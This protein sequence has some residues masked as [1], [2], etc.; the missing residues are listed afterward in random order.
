[1]VYPGHTVTAMNI[2]TRKSGNSCTPSYRQNC[3]NMEQLIYADITV[4]GI[5][6]WIENYH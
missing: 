5:T 1:M 3:S 4:E 2:L 6:R